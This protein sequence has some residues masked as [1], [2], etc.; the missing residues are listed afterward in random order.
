MKNSLPDFHFSHF[1]CSCV[2]WG[3]TPLALYLKKI[4]AI[5]KKE[6]LNFCSSSPYLH[7]NTKFWNGQVL[8]ESKFLY[9]LQLFFILILAYPKYFNVK[10]NINSVYMRLSLDWCARGRCVVDCSSM[11]P[12]SR[13]DELTVAL[14]HLFCASP[15]SWQLLRQRAP[16]LAPP[17][18]A[19]SGR[20]SEELDFL[21][22][23][24]ARTPSQLPPRMPLAQVGALGSV[25]FNPFWLLSHT[26]CS[27]PSG[28][29]CSS[30]CLRLS[31]RTLRSE[32]QLQ[33]S[34]SHTLSW[35]FVWMLLLNIWIYCL[36]FESTVQYLNQGWIIE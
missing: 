35:E 15:F 26:F 27:L 28:L 8:K 30:T 14:L 11:P 6:I 17:S 9:A 21:V 19:N 2:A 32:L 22:A 3:R 25:G 34:F 23:L 5:R 36:M 31:D 13:R 16:A 7:D 12:P 18:S 1:V 24:L 20:P 29:S 10:M 4:L 33:F